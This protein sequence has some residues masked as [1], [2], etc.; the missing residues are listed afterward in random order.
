MSFSLSNLRLQWHPGEK[1]FIQCGTD[2][3]S[4][5]PFHDPWKMGARVTYLLLGSLP[6]VA[7]TES[8][9]D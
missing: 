8:G 7:L 5:P 1:V 6:R 2:F 4:N 3:K 9:A